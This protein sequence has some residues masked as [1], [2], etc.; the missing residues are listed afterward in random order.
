MDYP[1]GA[2]GGLPGIVRNI[3]L[4][5]YSNGLPSRGLY[6]ELKSPG[7]FCL[8]PYSNGLP[9][10]GDIIEYSKELIDLS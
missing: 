9:S 6:K 1:L 7:L 10:R 2:G 3:G 5:P 4:N 8:N